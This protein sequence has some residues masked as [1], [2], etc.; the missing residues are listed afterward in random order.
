MSADGRP[1]RAKKVGNGVEVKGRFKKEGVDE[2]NGFV[3]ANW[4]LKSFYLLLEDCGRDKLADKLNG[5][6]KALYI[7][8]G[9]RRFGPEQ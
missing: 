6:R 4:I 8:K 9:E 7:S 5:D 2:I 1:T 3:E